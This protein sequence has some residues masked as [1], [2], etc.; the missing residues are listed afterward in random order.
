MSQLR[1]ET[2]QNWVDVVPARTSLIT[3]V[4]LGPEVPGGHMPS[5]R[6]SSPRPQHEQ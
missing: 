3:E 2:S 6:P 5:K 4:Y 1:M